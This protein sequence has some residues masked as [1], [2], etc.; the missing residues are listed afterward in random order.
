MSTITNLKSIH[1]RRVAHIDDERAEGNS[2]IVTL[3]THWYWADEPDCGVRSFDTIKELKEGIKSD[4]MIYRF[5][6]AKLFE[7]PRTK[8]RRI[9]P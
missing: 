3:C 6:P 5:D 1:A 7:N 2:I 4:K 9:K 8:N